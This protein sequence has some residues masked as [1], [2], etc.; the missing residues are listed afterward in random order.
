MDQ[1]NYNS[2]FQGK[3]V[4]ET[5]SSEKMTKY[6]IKKKKP[7]KSFFSSLIY[8]FTNQLK[9]ISNELFSPYMDSG[10][11][12][13]S[14]F[15][16]LSKRSII[17]KAIQN[18]VQDIS[19]IIL[20][21]KKTIQLKKREVR[22]SEV[23]IQ[24]EIKQKKRSLSNRSIILKALQKS[25]KDISK[26]ILN[27]K[28]TIKFKKKEIRKSEV[29]IQKGIKQKKRSLSNRSMIL[30]ASQNSFKDI[31]KIIL[32]IKKTIKFKKK[33]IRKSEVLIQ[34]KIKQKKREEFILLLKNIIFLKFIFSPKKKIISRDILKINKKLK[35]KRKETLISYVKNI[36]SLNFLLKPNKKNAS[37]EL[38]LINQKL[39]KKKIDEFKTRIV[40]L[41]QL[42][43]SA[44]KRSISKKML[45]RELKEKRKKRLKKNISDF[46]TFPNRS[47]ISI[48]GFLKYLF[49]NIINIKS[50]IN[51]L[52]ENI[53]RINTDQELKNRFL[54]TYSN[55]SLAF[56][57][58]FLFVYYI[59]Q[60]V[61]SI[62]CTSYSIPIVL[63]YFDIIYQV[64]P[65]STL[66]NRF[67]I[68]IIFGSAPFFSLLLSVIFYRFFKLSKTRFKYLRVY[69]LW[70]MIHSFVF[71]F[72]AYIVGAI[73]RSG[74]VYFTEWLFFSYM[75]DIEEI[76]FIVCCLIALISIGYFS[77]DFFLSTAYH[78]DLI[79]FKNKKYFKFAHI[80]LPW[81]TGIFILNIF[82]F[83]NITVYNILMYSSIL[84][85]LIPAMFDYQNYK[86]QQIV[87]VK[88]KQ[89][90]SF[91]KWNII[92]SVILIVLIRYLLNDGIWLN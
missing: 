31:S 90:Y 4:K 60:I 5:F 86:T 51:D 43:F 67:N 3:W 13:K 9:S 28:K 16:S 34:K 30:K 81:L 85:I 63:Y 1:Q 74:F 80:L 84:L 8:Q 69:M 14:I 91:L 41:S 18:S 83:P 39:R 38:L 44:K 54:Y 64:G 87:I 65:Y 40:R 58:T 36:I 70:G 71:Y 56:I 7:K 78:K 15:E 76:I 21:I 52:T 89:K 12:K 22:K 46:K 24:K 23:L 53:N 37:K 47:L 92:V 32:N 75:F 66:W 59:N 48:L 6:K 55:S 29:L 77:S 17:L 19:K 50:K 33:E 61:T 26:I 45:Q 27:I 2:Q 11:R 82:N 20:S 73:T 49:N 10:K 79:S 88:S 35:Q 57:I 72:G 62:L 42:K 25:F 68:L